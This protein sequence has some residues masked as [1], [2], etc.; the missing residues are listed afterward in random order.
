M[1]LVL[2]NL[3]DERQI[4]K[5][6]D[7][8]LEMELTDATVMDSEALE[9]LA[10]QTNPLFA[11]V[12]NLFGQNLAY[13]RTIILCLPHRDALHDVVRLCGRDG[14]DLVDPAVASLW[15]VPCEAYAP[16]RASA[17]GAPE[18]A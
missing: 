4:H 14:V 10:V 11:E 6:V 8:L 18:G 7:V 16:G 15:I 12:G 3:K 13:Q 17:A 1:V 2:L 9:N 5:V